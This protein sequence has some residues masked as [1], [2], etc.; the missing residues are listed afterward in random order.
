MQRDNDTFT[1]DIRYVDKKKKKI[2]KKNNNK[3]F[4]HIESKIQK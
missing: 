2:K 3:F 4:I 1:N